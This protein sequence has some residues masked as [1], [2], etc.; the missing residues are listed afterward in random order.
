VSEITLLIAYSGS[1]DMHLSRVIGAYES[2][3][4]ALEVK[5]ELD[6]WA[7]GAR[8]HESL[9][10]NDAAGRRVNLT[11]EDCDAANAARAAVLP[12]RLSGGI[13]TK[14]GVGWR[15]ESVPWVRRP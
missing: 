4:E 14:T 2:K 11:L 10:V 6:A 7:I 8:V 12:E 3:D 1:Y 15:L 9:I 13:D 5:S